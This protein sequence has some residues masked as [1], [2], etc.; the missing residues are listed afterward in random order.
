LNT[1]SNIGTIEERLRTAA[2]HL[3]TLAGNVGATSSEIQVQVDQDWARDAVAMVPGTQ[4]LQIVARQ[5]GVGFSKE[6]GDS[7]KLASFLARHEIPNEL[8]GLIHEL[9]GLES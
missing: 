4:V 7:E 5:F 8:V 2:E 9:S 3:N 1:R 6:K